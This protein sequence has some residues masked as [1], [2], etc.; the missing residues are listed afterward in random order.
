MRTRELLRLHDTGRPGINALFAEAHSAD[1]DLERGV[2]WTLP[3][4]RHDAEARHAGFRAPEILE[5]LDLAGHPLLRGVLRG[6]DGAG[7]E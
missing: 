1:W 6:P 5:A 3:V 7:T 4:G 2:D